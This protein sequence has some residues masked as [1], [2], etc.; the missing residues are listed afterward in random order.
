M[1]TLYEKDANYFAFFLPE[2]VLIQV[3]RDVVLSQTDLRTIIRRA[4]VHICPP[5]LNAKPRAGYDIIEL[6]LR[7]NDVIMLQGYARLGFGPLP[8]KHLLQHRDPKDGQQ[9]GLVKLIEG[10]F[11]HRIQ[12]HDALQVFEWLVEN[13]ACVQD[14]SASDLEPAPLYHAT[15]SMRPRPP[16]DHLTE[17]LKWSTNTAEMNTLCDMIDMLCEKGAVIDLHQDRFCVKGDPKHLRRANL[18]PMKRPDNAV[19]I[20]MLPHCPSS[21]LASL[22]KTHSSRDQVFTARSKLWRRF[23]PDLPRGKHRAVTNM[24]WIVTRIHEELFDQRNIREYGLC[25]EMSILYEMRLAFLSTAEFTDSTE[26]EALK[27]LVAAIKEIEE[28]LMFGDIEGNEHEAES[29]FK[30]CRA[31]SCLATESYRTESL[32]DADRFG[33]R[34][35]QFVINDAWDPRVQWVQWKADIELP[36]LKTPFGKLLR[37]DTIE[38]WRQLIIELGDKRRWYEVTEQDKWFMPVEEVK[39]ALR[40]TEGYAMAALRV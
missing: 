33:E 5:S 16:I 7:N 6:A 31:V 37:E 8:T 11:Q 2:H 21:F 39:V 24:E 22:L 19:E 36:A 15:R 40:A 28:S 3:L 38:T 26:L 30:L 23:G 18:D 34:R 1:A 14:L 20:A 35:H 27:K 25:S 32:Q 12:A 13:E 9:S 29:W 17:M 4:R 10:F